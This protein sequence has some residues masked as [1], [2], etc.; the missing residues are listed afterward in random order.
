[1]SFVSYRPS[2]PVF[3][4]FSISDRAF[5]VKQKTFSGTAEYG[6]ILAAKRFGHMLPFRKEKDSFFVG[7][8]KPPFRY[9]TTF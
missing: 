4:G 3:D 5:E 9:E 7:S 6:I 2:P 1:M 8:V